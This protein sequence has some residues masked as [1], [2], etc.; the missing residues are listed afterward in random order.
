[1]ARASYAI[2]VREGSSSGAKYR[3]SNTTS[4]R[5]PGIDRRAL[6]AAAPVL[7]HDV[8]GARSRRRLVDEHARR[9]P[10]QLVELLGPERRRRYQQTIHLVVEQRAHR[11]GDAVRVLARIDQDQPVAALLERRL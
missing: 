5:S 3:S 1:M 6:R 9:R 4:A 2:A 10:E 7:Q 8:A 11:L